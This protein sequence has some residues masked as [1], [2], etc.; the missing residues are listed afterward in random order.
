MTK[1]VLG[2]RNSRGKWML[3]DVSFAN[4]AFSIT[5]FILEGRVSRVEYL[6]SAT[7]Y[8]CNQR[9]SFQL[10]LSELASAYG[11]SHVAGSFDDAGRST[12]SV[13]FNTQNMDIALHLSV[14]TDDC[15]TRVIFKMRD[16]KDAS[17]L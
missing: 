10:A 13:S 12:Q 11:E 1:P 4:Q 2:P 16:V 7:R 6:S 8:E 9:T 15:S 17:E 5:Y 3:P 14:S